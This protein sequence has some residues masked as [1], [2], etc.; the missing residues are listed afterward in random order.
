M[1]SVLSQETKEILVRISMDR[2]R[3]NLLKIHE[4]RFLGFLVQRIPPVIK[5]DMLTFIGFSGSLIVLLGFILAVYVHKNYLLLG[6]PGFVINWFGDSLDGRLAYFRKKPRKWYGFSLDL[7]TDWLS[8]ILIGL[9]YLIYTEGRWELAGF[10]FVVMYGWAM[11]IA[12]IRYKVTGKYTID[13]GI[14]GPTEVRIVIS[15]IM[16]AEIFIK[17]TMVYSA[18]VVSAILFIVNIF[19]TLK[20]LRVASEKDTAEKGGKL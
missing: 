8:T 14:F 18:V 20:L 10:G 13:S 12:I 15:A 1:K 7:V 19:D 11:I 3:T 2:K 9:G 17:N 16:L 6:V 5:P 4:Q